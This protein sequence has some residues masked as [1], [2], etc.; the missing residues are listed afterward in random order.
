MK[1]FLI[2]TFIVLTG[3]VTAFSCRAYT[4]IN[5]DS[6]M[7]SAVLSNMSAMFADLAPLLEIVIPILLVAIVVS[8]IINRI[9]G[10]GK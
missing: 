8:L 2:V 7:T 9:A 1:K 6:D 3:L 10:G 5:W 4:F